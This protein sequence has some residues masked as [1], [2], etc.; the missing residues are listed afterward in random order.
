MKKMQIFENKCLRLALGIT[1]Q[2]GTRSIDMHDLTDVP[3]I[4]TRKTAL[5]AKTF[6]SL[7][8]TQCFKDLMLNHEI[9]Q[10]GSVSNTILE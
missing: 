9:V 4:K 5:A 6:R 10:K 8:N 2:D 7:E 3:M 1:Y